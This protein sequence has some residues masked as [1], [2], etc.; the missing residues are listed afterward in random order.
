MTKPIIKWVGGKTQIL[1]EVISKFPK[2]MKNYKEIFIGG[3]SVILKFLNELN[4][5]N[6][7]VTGKIYA[8]DINDTLIHLYKNIQSSPQELYN[9]VLHIANSYCLKG[10]SEQEEF[11]YE[12]REEYNKLTVVEKRS[13]FGSSL[14]IFLNKTCFRG[15]YRTG[16]K[17]FNVPFGSYKNPEIINLEHILEVS[18]LIKDV[19][20]EVSAFPESMGNAEENDFLYLDP[21][22]FPENDK[23]F[24]SYN[25][26]GFSKEQHSSLFDLMKKL[27]TKSVL[28]LMSNS[29]TEP[30]RNS[31]NEFNIETIVCKRCINSKNPSSKTNELLI[32]NF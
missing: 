20:F 8:F 6:F 23:S 9:Q 21:P 25:R 16:P 5:G 29:D 13:I 15:L 30:V 2:N 12:K 17:G 19:I 18:R 11:Y 10:P 22:Y 1:D 7:T 27:D 26:D 24:V 3:G 32:K 14:F 31:L 4:K 28:F